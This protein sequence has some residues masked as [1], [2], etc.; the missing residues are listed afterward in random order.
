MKN[1]QDLF[2]NV[3]KDIERYIDEQ[4]ETRYRERILNDSEYDLQEEKRV[5][6][7]ERI[8]LRA[9]PD[10]LSAT[11]I[12]KCLGI[13]RSRIYELFRIK[14]DHGGIPNFAIGNSRRAQKTDF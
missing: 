11:D 8:S 7:N 10:I 2:K 6:A 5:I 9:L 4:V 12:A 14:E 3:I 13:S 1:K